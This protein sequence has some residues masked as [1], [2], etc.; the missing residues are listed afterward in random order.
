MPK[1]CI[2]NQGPPPPPKKKNDGPAISY[3]PIVVIDFDGFPINEIHF[4]TCY[5]I[6]LPARFWEL[7]VPVGNRCHS[8]WSGCQRFVGRDLSL[9]DG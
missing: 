3:Q 6:C 4:P 7:Q 2:T 8:Y 1:N 9:Q 5:F